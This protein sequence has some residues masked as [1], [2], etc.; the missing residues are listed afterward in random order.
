MYT[1]RE[2]ENFAK[3]MDWAKEALKK[4]EEVFAS[5][6]DPENV[7]FWLVVTSVRVK[8]WQQAYKKEFAD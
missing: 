2:K 7:K 5:G 1:E 4:A 8:S 3:T 6:G